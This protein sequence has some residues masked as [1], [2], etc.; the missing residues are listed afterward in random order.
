MRKFWES[1]IVSLIRTQKSLLALVGVSML[2]YALTTAFYA[3]LSGPALQYLFSADISDVFLTPKGQVRSFFAWMP[4]GWL[5]ALRKLSVSSSI[6]ILPVILI[7]AA[8]LKGSAQTGQFYGMGRISQYVLATIRT[9]L[10]A[11]ITHAQLAALRSKKQGDLLSRINH[12]AQRIEEAVFYGVGPLMR[13]PIVLFALLLYLFFTHWQLAMITLIALPLTIIPI[14]KLT[15]WLKG[16]ANNEQEASAEMHHIANETLRGIEVVQAFQGEETQQMRFANAIEKYKSY[17]T[18]SYLI[19]AVRTPIMEILGA[20]AISSLIIL[21]TIWVQKNNADPAE[22]MSFLV[23]FLL[24]YEPLKRMGHMGDFMAAGLAAYERIEAI[25]KLARPIEEPKIAMSLASH[26]HQI[27]LNNVY[28]SYAKNE[29]IHNCS[30]ELNSG[31]VVA[32][33]GPSGAGKTTIARLMARFYDVQAGSITID[34]TDIRDVALHDLRKKI[35]WVGQDTILFNLSIAENI[36]FGTNQAK[37]SQIESAARAAHAD[38]FIRNLPQGYQTI[39]GEAGYTLSGGQKQRL[40]IARALLRNA[41]IIILDEAT[42]SLD[43]KSEEMI[44]QALDVLIHRRT[45]MVIAHRL[46]TIR[47]AQRIVVL[48]GGKIESIGEHDEL[49]EEGG[50]YAQLYATQFST[51]AVPNQTPMPI[52]PA[53]PIAN[54]AQTPHW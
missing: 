35:S 42:S 53:I 11:R 30:F 20:I 44:Q 36:A 22:L 14:V 8:L 41:P 7:L 1:D 24:M 18:Q 10:F 33:V 29:V 50:T 12:D 17:M 3:F 28:F 31:E 6:F 47:R 2:V 5:A 32:L 43:A 51:S 15:R 39:I 27:C 48:N 37:Q 34:G 40:A 21:I 9:R 45:T 13:E 16:V 26:P 49:M 54:P 19:R 46:S 38:T 4:T 25:E 23:A 52:Q